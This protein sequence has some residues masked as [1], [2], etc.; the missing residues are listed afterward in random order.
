MGVVAHA[1]V[2]G[3]SSTVPIITVALDAATGVTVIVLCCG[4]CAAKLQIAENTPLRAI[5]TV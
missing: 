5:K 1:L 3:M 4:A 2:R